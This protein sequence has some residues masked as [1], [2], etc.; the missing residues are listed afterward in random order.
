MTGVGFKVIMYSTNV[1]FLTL[2]A[3]LVSKWGLK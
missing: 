1:N 3:F 2:A